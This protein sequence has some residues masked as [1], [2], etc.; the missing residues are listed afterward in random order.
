MARYTGPKHRLARREGINI[1]EKSSRSLEKKLM[2]PPGMHGKKGSRRKVSEYGMQL[3]E[4]QKLKRTYGILEKQFRRYIAIA[5]KKKQNT[6]E[7]L[8]QELEARLD[9]VVF[10]LGF[11]QSRPQARQLVSHRH[12][13]V[14]GARVNIP[15]YAVKE[16]DTVSLDPRILKNNEVMK[17]T[18]EEA[19]LASPYLEKK[20]MIGKLVRLPK[21]DEVA[22]P[23]DYQLVI[24]YYSR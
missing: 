4:K 15:S 20:A 7:A 13:L 21:I 10:R 2:I 3:R 14:N 12:V 22:N 6:A 23:I 9:N 17:K 5:E 16:G 1:L 8:V 24:E 11:T 19:E 18:I